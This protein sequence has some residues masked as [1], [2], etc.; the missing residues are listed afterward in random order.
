MMVGFHAAKDVR[1]DRQLGVILAGGM[2]RRMGG[3]DKTLLE[4]NRKPLLAHVL[5]RLTP[6]VA[7]MALNANGD[8][9]RFGR[10]G[11][12][13]VDD[14]DSERRG[15]LSGVLAGM[16]L[17]GELGF[18][19]IVTVAGDTPFFPE[20]LVEK[21]MLAADLQSAPIVLAASRDSG[22]RLRM[23]P[24]FGLWDVELA[25]DLAAALAG[26]TRKILDW[27]DTH[28]TVP[29]EFASCNGDPF[30]NINTPED[31]D[32]AERMQVESDT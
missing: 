8:P 14:G 1:D 22:G 5:G 6:Q 21:L 17:A 28:W 27:T 16:K 10:F 23:H 18:R 25:D 31:L 2:A 13:V 32:V 26:G 30:F 9:S 15:P 12:R 24:T 4:L 19:R 11:L 7:D 29:A 3:R 20:N